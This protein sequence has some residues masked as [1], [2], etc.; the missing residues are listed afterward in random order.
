MKTN[1]VILTLRKHGIR[2]KEKKKTN[3]LEEKARGGG[4]H[5]YTR[6]HYKSMEKYD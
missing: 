5:M 3:D 6:C 2:P 1:E 4:K